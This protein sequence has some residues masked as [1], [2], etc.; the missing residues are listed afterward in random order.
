MKKSLCATVFLLVLC[1]VLVSCGNSSKNT[2][3]RFAETEKK[4]TVNLAEE[5]VQSADSLSRGSVSEDLEQFRQILPEVCD[6]LMYQSFVFVSQPVPSDVELRMRGKSLPDTAKISLSQL[7][8][9]TLPYYDFDGKVQ[10]GE[11]VCNKRIASD[12]LQIFRALFSEAYPICS[13]HLVDDF[14]ASDEASMQANN[15][16]CFNYRTIEGTKTLSRHAFGMA[17]DVNP[18]QNPCVRGNRIRPLTASEYVDRSKDFA[19]K[20]DETDFCKKTFTSH[21]F[22]WGGRWSR[23]KDYQHF[24]R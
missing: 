15:T 11:M 8:Y 16:S 7:R 1:V 18:L 21:G 9:L 17:V 4:E 14:G 23:M 10:I 19:H 20:I 24:E 3:D 13:I 12:L 2:D 5:Y 22:R 6:T